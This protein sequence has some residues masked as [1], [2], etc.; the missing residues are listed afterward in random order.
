MCQDK[1]P[2][3]RSAH[4]RDS[5]TSNPAAVPTDSP[6]PLLLSPRP[7]PQWRSRQPLE[8]HVSS[9]NHRDLLAPT[10]VFGDRWTS[11][12]PLEPPECIAWLSASRLLPPTA[13]RGRECGARWGPFPTDAA[14]GATRGLFENLTVGVG[15]LYPPAASGPAGYTWRPRPSCPHK[16]GGQ[17]PG[18]ERRLLTVYGGPDAWLI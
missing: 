7:T 6:P 5:F 11:A 8:R 3:L 18:P 16:D 13:R 14:W 1:G 12:L 4:F 15:G 17:R 9:A 10:S 2:S